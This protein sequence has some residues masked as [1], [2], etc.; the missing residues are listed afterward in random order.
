MFSEFENQ[1]QHSI[2]LENLSIKI[3]TLKKLTYYLYITQVQKLFFHITTMHQFFSRG[4]LIYWIRV[5]MID[6]RVR[7]K[8]YWG[9][10]D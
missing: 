7:I 3:F 10:F 6:L 4:Y 2:L 1:Y 8:N 5:I 9:A